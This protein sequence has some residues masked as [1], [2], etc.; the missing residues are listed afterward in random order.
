M[1]SEYFAIKINPVAI[2]SRSGHSWSYID[3]TISRS[4]QMTVIENKV[5][6]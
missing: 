6:V 4:D 3:W 2:F 1:F 5:G